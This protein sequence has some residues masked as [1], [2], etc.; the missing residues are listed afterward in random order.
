MNFSICQ[1]AFDIF[2]V[3][4]HT[5]IIV[6]ES[7][8]DYLRLRNVFDFRDMTNLVNFAITWTNFVETVH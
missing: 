1:L 8:Y 7:F 3:I 5:H 2:V 6:P 4:R